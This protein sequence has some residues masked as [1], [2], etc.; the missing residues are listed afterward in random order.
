MRITADCIHFYRFLHYGP[1]IGHQK[2]ATSLICR[3]L[4]NNNSR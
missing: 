1:L 3:A 2:G 4:E